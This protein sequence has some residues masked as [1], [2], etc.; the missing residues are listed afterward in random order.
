M[1]SAPAIFSKVIT[2]NKKYSRS[3]EISSD[4]KNKYKISIYNEDEKLKIS[5][6]NL[7]PL[8]LGNNEYE[9]ESP[10]ED[11][12]NNK[13]LSLCDTANDM[14]EELFNLLDNKKYSLIENGNEIILSIEVP[15]KLIKAITFNLVKKEKDPNLIMND[16]IKVNNELKSEVEILS[17][18]T[19]D[20]KDDIDYLKEKNSESKMNDLFKKLSDKINDLELKMN[21][22]KLGEQKE[23]QKLI[24][25]VNILTQKVLAL[26]KE[27]EQEKTKSNQ[28]L[29]NFKQLKNQ[30]TNTNN[31]NTQNKK[32]NED[33]PPFHSS[34]SETLPELLFQSFFDG[35]LGNKNLGKKGKSI[36]HQHVLIYSDYTMKAP[37]YANSSYLCDNCKKEF[38]RNVDN[39]HCKECHFDLCERCF[40]NSQ[41]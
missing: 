2:P 15:M 19:K 25:Q 5:A 29:E 10:I 7:N 26:E 21:E 38:P 28:I 9:R 30:S 36:L 37:E 33:N 6:I 22:Q 16:L 40:K 14:L 17:I 18:K 3:F 39:F 20:L 35:I 23:K 4:K 31:M 13:Y 12:R 34:K 1:E 8:D 27:L 41:Y 24:S 11:L 32:N